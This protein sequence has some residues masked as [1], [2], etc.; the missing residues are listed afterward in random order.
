MGLL[1]YMV[2]LFIIFEEPPYCFPYLLSN[3]YSHQQCPRVSVSA[4]PC[5]RLL[6]LGIFLVTAILTGVRRYLTVVLICISLVVSDA[7]HLF[8]YL[9]AIRMSSGNCLSRSSAHFF[10][11][12]FLLLSCIELFIYFGY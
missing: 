9:L 10:N 3:L 1:D 5:R 12:I 2:V 8:T 11:R 7:E 6:P 4:H